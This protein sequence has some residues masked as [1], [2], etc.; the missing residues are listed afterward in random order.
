[1][2]ITSPN[3]SAVSMTETLKMLRFP[4]IPFNGMKTEVYIENEKNNPI[5]R[6]DVVIQ[7]VPRNRTVARRLKSRLRRLKNCTTFILKPNLIKVKSERN[8]Q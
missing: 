6:S 4:P 1:M 5:H 7:D 3:G 8:F 2:T